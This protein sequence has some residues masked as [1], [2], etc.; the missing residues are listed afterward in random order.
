MSTATDTPDFSLPPPEGLAYIAAIRP[1]LN[2]L[3][4][5]TVWTAVLV[6][7]AIALLLFSTSELRRKP[8]FIFNLIAILLGI[9]EGVLNGYLEVRTDTFALC[10]FNADCLQGYSHYLSPNIH[11]TLCLHGLHLSLLLST[12]LH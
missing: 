9:A 5:G 8:I 2:L 12:N 10:T 7:I 4:I 11:T 6:P 3:M 1:S